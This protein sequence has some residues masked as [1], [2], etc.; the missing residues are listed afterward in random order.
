[1]TANTTQQFDAQQPGCWV[2]P[3]WGHY[4][5][6]QA[7]VRAITELGWEEPDAVDGPGPILTLALFDL[8]HCGPQPQEGSRGWLEQRLLAEQAAAIAQAEGWDL[9]EDLPSILAQELEQ[10]E[11]WLDQM[12]PAGHYWGHSPHGMG[13]GLW[14]WEEEG[15]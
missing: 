14:A 7:L 4:S 1:M 8:S 9:E 12:A 15:L 11:Q 10:A 6:A 3:W 2:D 13:W 5:T